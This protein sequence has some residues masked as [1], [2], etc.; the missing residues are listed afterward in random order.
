MG[1]NW[2]IVSQLSNDNSNNSAILSGEFVTVDS[3][4]EIRA[5]IDGYIIP[6]IGVSTS[7][8]EQ[9]LIL[10]ELWNK[11]EENFIY[12]LKGSFNIIISTPKKIHIFNDTIAQKKFFR[13]V[14]NDEVI[15]TN[16]I[17]LI[18]KKYDLEID[19]I[20]M[21]LFFLFEH[22][23]DGRTLFK[24]TYFSKPA[25]KVVLQN[26]GYEVS[27]YWSPEDLLEIKKATLDLTD[28]AFY[29]REIIKKYLDYLAPKDI[30]MTLTGGNDSRMVLA[31]LLSIGKKSNAFTFGNPNSFDG[32]IASELA[33]KA[34]VKHTNHYFRDTNLD[35]F[36]KYSSRIVESGNS[37]INIHRAHRLYAIE[38][39]IKI[40]PNVEMVF[41]GFMGGDF[42]K[43]IIYDDYI[44]SK[45]FRLINNE[46]ADLRQSIL[47]ILHFHFIYPTHDQIDQIIDVV[48]QQKWMTKKGKLEREFL[49]V[50]E[51]VGG[52]HDFQ[53]ISIF[54]S[55]VRYSVN[56]FM[57]IDFLQQLIPS[58]FGMLSRNNSAD[59]NISRLSYAD[60][61]VNIT[62]NLAPQLS[63]IP[64]SKKGYYTANEFLGNKYLLA[65]KRLIRYK[66]NTKFPQNFPYSEWIKTF[67]LET[68]SQ[69]K[70]YF[71]DLFDQKSYLKELVRAP[72]IPTEGFWHRYTNMA[73]IVLNI[74]NFV[75]FRKLS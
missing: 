29:W 37:L 22:Y 62:H 30:T 9:Y 57:D 31:A 50:F 45:F 32:V 42:V 75:K 36:K 15:F 39:E 17:E 43:G 58:P 23:V 41:G 2:S 11:Y 60:L 4:N 64:Y 73:N 24:N 12:Y 7:S 14:L 65:I 8:H 52:M 44:T 5:L 71:T 66:K 35:W 25:T 74:E 33:Q 27:N 67:S 28:F 51:I 10:S 53:D 47:D 18:S 68:I 19:V 40:N 26:C 13:F 63:N 34:G 70:N 21:S 55:K 61:H 1:N 38:Q 59:K 46:G 49:Y 3:D 72:V 54:Q 48:L 16:N 6:R 20:G 56:P 69:R